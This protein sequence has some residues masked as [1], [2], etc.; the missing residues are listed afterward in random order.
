MA[1]SAFEPRPEIP[2]ARSCSA[3][4]GMSVKEVEVRILSGPNCGKMTLLYSKGLQE[5]VERGKLIYSYENTELLGTFLVVQWL[6]R[7][8]PSAGG[9]GV[10]PGQGTRSHRPQLRV[11]Q[12][13][14]HN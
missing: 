5:A 11:L 9:L 2:E 3:H 6:R 13:R 8:S 4:E 1:K 12:Q 14:S 7:C 10:I